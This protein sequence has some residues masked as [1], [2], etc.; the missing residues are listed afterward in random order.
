MWYTESTTI[1]SLRR[2]KIMHETDAKCLIKPVFDFLISTQFDGRLN[3]EEYQLSLLCFQDF[4]K[5][6]EPY[7]IREKAV[8]IIRCIL[9]FE[10]E[11]GDCP[12]TLKEVV[13][14]IVRRVRAS[15]GK[16]LEQEVNA[17]LSLT[18][19]RDV[20]FP[21]FIDLRSW[22]RLDWTRSRKPSI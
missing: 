19:R 5:D 20:N 7:W 3:D 6:R 10:N 1:F 18:L 2:D 9:D 16:E 15:L 8:R 12:A 14:A 22:G 4:V 17:S 11:V 21:E 13:L